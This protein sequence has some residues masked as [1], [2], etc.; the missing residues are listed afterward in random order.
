MTWDAGRWPNFAQAEFRCRHTGRCEMDPDFLDRLQ[1]LRTA[2]GE[3]L[4]ISSGFRDPAHPVEAGKSEPG[5]HAHGVAADVE[6]D[7]RLAFRILALAPGLGFTGIGVSQRSGRG[8]FVHL[9]TWPRAPRPNV[10]S[11]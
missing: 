8:R 9:D 1:A 6:A 3:P 11:Y 4:A 7:T 2:L 10:W 5:A